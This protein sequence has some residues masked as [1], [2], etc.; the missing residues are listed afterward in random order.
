MHSSAGLR[1]KRRRA[2][3]CRLSDYKPKLRPGFYIYHEFYENFLQEFSGEELKELIDAV[4]R[5][6]KDLSQEPSASSMSEPTF[7]SRFIRSAYR[8]W[9]SSIVRDDGKYKS[10][11]MRN[12]NNRKGGKT[13]DE[14]DNRSSPLVTSGDERSRNIIVTQ[15]RNIIEDVNVTPTVIPN[16]PAPSRPPNWNALT[17]DE[18]RKWLEKD[19]AKRFS[20]DKQESP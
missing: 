16:H 13:K 15:N 17:A 3:E 18:K 12:R 9:C 6:S 10:T 5:Y 2:R 20:A 1:K 19:F 11:C 4:Y 7:S 8:T 14:R